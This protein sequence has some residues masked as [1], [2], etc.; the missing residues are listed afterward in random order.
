[1]EHERFE[2]SSDDW[3]VYVTCVGVAFNAVLL[4]VLWFGVASGW[5]IF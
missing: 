1:M 2:V 3:S 4:V 5:L